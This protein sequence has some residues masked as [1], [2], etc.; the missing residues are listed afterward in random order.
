[1]NL[2]GGEAANWGIRNSET[3]RIVY[4]HCEQK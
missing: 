3:G 4:Q 2:V 1:M